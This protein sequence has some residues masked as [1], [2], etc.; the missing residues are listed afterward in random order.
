MDEPIQSYRGGMA[1]R[2]GGPNADRVR[3]VLGATALLIALSAA[4]CAGTVDGADQELLSETLAATPSASPEPS[5]PADAPAGDE[6]S[7]TMSTPQ[8][9]ATETPDEHSEVGELVEGFPEEL[10]PLPPDAVVLVTSAVP[11]GEADVQEVSLNV[12]TSAS[13]EEILELYRESLVR[14]G[15]TEVPPAT[16]QTTLAAEAVFTR[17]GGDELISVGV[18]DVDG[19]RTLTVGGR[20]RTEPGAAP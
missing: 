12:R 5:A 7:A 9:Q 13:A 11:V 20:I 19:A 8:P 16:T 3:A 15:F 14:A 1:A 2:T 18:L 4:G 6:P 10:L 17:S